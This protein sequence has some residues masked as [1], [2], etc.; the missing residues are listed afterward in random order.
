LRV[1]YR[2]CQSTARVIR[3]IDKTSACDGFVKSEVL[4]CLLN[5]H[6]SLYPE[7]QQ[8][9]V[10]AGRINARFTFGLAVW[11]TPKHSQVLPGTLAP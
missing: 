7:Q 6:L 2:E 4:C 10:P 1:E 9:V 11:G 8:V 3:V 5:E